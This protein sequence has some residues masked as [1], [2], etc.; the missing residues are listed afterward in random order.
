MR[1][2]EIRL[3]K[4][5][6]V[7]CPMCNLRTARYDLGVKKLIEVFHDSSNKPLNKPLHALPSWADPL[8]QVLMSMMTSRMLM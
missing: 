7:A 4:S 1:F 2:V 5:E 3:C 6:R 8:V